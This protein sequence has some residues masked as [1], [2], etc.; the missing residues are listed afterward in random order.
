M[1]MSLSSKSRNLD[2]GPSRSYPDK[3][4]RVLFINSAILAGADTWI[5]LLLLRNLPQDRFELYA[6]GQPGSPSPA[7]E[8]LRAIPGVALRQT[9]FGPSLWQRSRLQKLTSIADAADKHP[10]TAESN[11]SRQRR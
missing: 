7:L 5:H 4:T 6:A 3:R 2:P 1:A 11:T 8:E 9:N 10:T